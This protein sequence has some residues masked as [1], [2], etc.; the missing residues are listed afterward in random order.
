MA[1]SPPTTYNSNTNLALGSIP[2]VDDPDTYEALLDIHNAIESLLKSSDI[3]LTTIF[4]YIT[5]QRK[6]SSPV[7][8]SNY[9]V[10]TTDGTVRVD[11]SGGDVIV[12]LHPVASGPGYKYNIKRVDETSGN[13][14][15]LLGDGA[16]PVDGHAAGVDISIL[17]SYTVKAHD[18]G[19]DII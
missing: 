17:S 11:A 13:S 9:T 19:W 18:T 7:I 6:F 14:V 15:T 12:T 1:D 10:L 3:D 8:T 16:E 4:A 5:K 2:Q